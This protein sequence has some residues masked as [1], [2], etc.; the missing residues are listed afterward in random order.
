ML[1]AALWGERGTGE[2]RRGELWTERLEWQKGFGWAWLSGLLA[3]RA[4]SCAANRRARSTAKSGWSRDA[5]PLLGAAA[6]LAPAL[7]GAPPLA[8]VAVAGQGRHLWA[9]VAVLRV[10]GQRGGG[11]AGAPRWRR[12]E[13]IIHRRVVAI[14][15]LILLWELPVRRL[16]PVRSG[17]AVRKP[18]AGH[19]LRPGPLGGQR[20]LGC[21]GLHRNGPRSLPPAQLKASCQRIQCS[22][23]IHN[24][25]GPGPTH[26]S[27]GA[28]A[29][30]PAPVLARASR[31]GMPPLRTATTSGSLRIS[32][33]MLCRAVRGA[34]GRSG[35]P[36]AG[37]Q[38]DATAAAAAPAPPS[39]PLA[40]QPRPCAPS[41]SGC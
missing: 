19:A 25:L 5:R 14:L 1:G 39:P 40:P 20:G 27:E 3:V 12:H 28:G 23:S 8:L 18:R 31:E 2:R 36:P 33:V 24:P 38:L 4:C 21:R 15:L 7:L 10:G 22:D 29:A 16:L 9:A 41:A 37:M 32:W 6:A 34:R 17:S 13:R 11:G 35:G 30:M 26:P